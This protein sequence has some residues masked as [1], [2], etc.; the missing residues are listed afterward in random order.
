MENFSFSQIPQDT[1]QCSSRRDG[2]WLIWNCAQCAGY[3]R[4]FN[5]VS[6]EMRTRRGGS[7]AQHTG[8]TDAA[9]LREAFAE[10]LCRN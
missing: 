5:F 9:D 4:R 1:H 8:S 3:E 10:T 7:L 2:D 6:G